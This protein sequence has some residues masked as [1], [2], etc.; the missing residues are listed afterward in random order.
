MSLAQNERKNGAVDDPR[1]SSYS[2][3]TILHS[4]SAGYVAGISGVVFGHPMDSAKVWLQ[5]KGANPTATAAPATTSSNVANNVST[6][7]VS[8]TPALSTSSSIAN[9]M[10]TL[11]IPQERGFNLRSIRSLYS[12]VTG[13]L[14]TVG[15]IQSINFGIYDSLRR[16]L[17]QQNHPDA[18]DSA[19]LNHDS[20]IN[21]AISSMAAGGV[22]AIFTSPLQVIKTKQQIM[23]WPFQKAIR[24]TLL[25]S[26]ARRNCYPGFGP[27]CVA[28]VFGRGIYFCTYESLKRRFLESKQESNVSITMYERC[29]SAAIS[30]IVCWTMIFPFDAIRNRMYAQTLSPCTPKSSWEM[31]KSMYGEQNSVRPFFRGFSVTVIRAGPVAAAVLPIFDATLEWLSRET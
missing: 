14:L 20:L 31:T 10:S 17:H 13:P 1:R 2:A 29:I 22:L 18:P 8:R 21:V 25:Q 24:D 3:K 12:G 11:A 15:M 26:S 6:G 16:V 9:N 23:E 19:Y 5:V 30:G 27:H 4:V 28:E 7:L